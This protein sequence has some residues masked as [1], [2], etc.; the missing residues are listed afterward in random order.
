MTNTEIHT[1]THY[2]LLK[3]KGR[4]TLESSQK[5]DTFLTGD[6]SKDCGFLIRNQE[7]ASVTTCKFLPNKL[8]EI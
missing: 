4:R 5:D 6:Q 7:Y 1:Q 8:A 3:T 2:K